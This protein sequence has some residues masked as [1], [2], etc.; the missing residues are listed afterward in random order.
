M[1]PGASTSRMKMQLV[2]RKYTP[3]VVNATENLDSMILNS[4]LQT[5]MKF[6]SDQKEVEWLQE[7]IDNCASKEKPQPKQHAVNKVNKNKK[8]TGQEM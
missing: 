2:P 8:R 5:C 3:E 1:D 6:L 7:L 4:F